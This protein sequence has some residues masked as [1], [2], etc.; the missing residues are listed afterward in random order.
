MHQSNAE[1]N[2]R[3]LFEAYANEA[4]VEAHRN[5]AHFQNLVIGQ[6]VPNLQNRE[7]ILA[8]QLEFK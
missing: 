4:A 6:I 2:T 3:I 5:S 7:V 1:A 8:S